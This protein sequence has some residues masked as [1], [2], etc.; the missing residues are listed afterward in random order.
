VPVLGFQ[1][2]HTERDV[3]TRPDVIIKNKN[4]KKSI[5]IDVVIPADKNV[6]QKEAEKALKTIVYV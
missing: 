4:R 1:G 3:T 5:M 2:V 6:T